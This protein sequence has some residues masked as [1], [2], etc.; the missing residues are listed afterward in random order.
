MLSKLHKQVQS[1]LNKHLIRHKDTYLITFDFKMS[2][3]AEAQI[4]T[5]QILKGKLKMLKE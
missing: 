4:K 5:I 3:A 2:S 1:K